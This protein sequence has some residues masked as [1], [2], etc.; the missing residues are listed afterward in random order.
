M[1][2]NIINSQLISHRNNVVT[3]EDKKF[4]FDGVFGEGD[5]YEVYVSVLLPLLEVALYQNKDATIIAFGAR[6][7]GNCLSYLRQNYYSWTT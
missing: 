7:T 4:V 5:E 1:Q 2:L 6:R 3:A